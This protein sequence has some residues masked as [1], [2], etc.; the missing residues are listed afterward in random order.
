MKL[1]Y[2]AC[3]AL[4]GGGTEASETKWKLTIPCK[5]GEGDEAETFK[6]QIEL[7]ELENNKQYAV[8][9]SRKG[10]TEMAHRVFNETYK[11][12][13]EHVKEEDKKEVVLEVAN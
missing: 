10:G 6:M 9:V 1:L 5:E 8:S 3:K 11:K 2:E 4:P 7:H 13:I 12:F